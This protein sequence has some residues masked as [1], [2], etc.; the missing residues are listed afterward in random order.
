MPRFQ[1][2]L[3]NLSGTLHIGDHAI[4]G[5]VGACEA[6]QRAGIKVKYLANTTKVPSSTL[7]RQLRSIGFDGAFVPS[8]ESIMT[9]ATATREIQI[10]GSSQRPEMQSC[11]NSNIQ[12]Y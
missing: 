5:A 2:A 1:A 6:L 9:S 3:I 12:T 8:Q 11:S 10:I 7:F 4:Q